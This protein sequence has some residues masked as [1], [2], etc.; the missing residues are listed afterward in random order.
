MDRLTRRSA[1]ALASSVALAP[2]VG[3][4]ES[5]GGSAQ[6]NQTFSDLAARWLDGYAKTRPAGATAM[7]DHRFD[8]EMDDVSTTGRAAKATLI[9]ETRTALA[10]IDRSK[11][12]RDNQVDAAMLDEQLEGETF[13]L[14]E[15]QDWAWDP[16]NYSGL[17]GGSLYSLMAR[18][19]APLPERLINATARM[20]KLPDLLAATRNQLVAERVPPIHAQTYS[21]QNG[22]A[23]S[24][25]DDLILTQASALPAAD[26]SR[27]QAA[28]EKAKAAIAEHQTWIDT[29]LAPNARG[30]FRLGPLYDKKL[31]LSIN[32]SIPKAELAARARQDAAAIRDEMFAI[33]EPLVADSPA[34][35]MLPSGLSPEARKLAIIGAALK[36]AAQERPPRERLMDD[37]RKTLDEATAFIREKDFITLPDAT[38]KIIEMPKFQQGVAVAYCDSPGPL[39]RRLDTFYAISPIPADWTDEQTKSFLSEYNTHMLYELSIHEAMPGHYLQIWHSNK[40]PSITRAVLGSGTFVEGWA[41]YAEDLMIEMGFGAD[42]PLRRLTNLKMR[43]RSV[44]N[45]ILDQGVHVEGWDEATAMRF[46]T[47]EAFQE[48]REAAGK[49]TRARVSSGQLSTYYVGWGEHHALRKDAEAR[50]GAAFNLK[51]YHDAA[52]SHGSPPAHFVRQLMFG[53]PIA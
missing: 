14:E 19:F 7:G 6:V 29:Q 20:E 45:A 42:N 16:L 3:C 44:T 48:E 17:A 4:G 15:L 39:D 52:L 46:M 35:K 53:E 22:G 49:W 41:C 32:S 26:L 24:I 36:L 10:A 12:S 1:I 40:H 30:D 37:A 28:A 47:Q 25:I 8:A 5:G 21:R 34:I 50:D 43:L 38:V 33:G 18:E 11:L 9:S 27:L 51:K 13:I 23:V 2:L 31:E